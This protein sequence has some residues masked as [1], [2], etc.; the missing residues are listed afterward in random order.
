[1]AQSYYILNGVCVCVC[2]QCLQAESWSTL[3]RAP[4][5]AALS[6]KSGGSKK[7]G[8]KSSSGTFQS[9]AAAETFSPSAKLALLE[10]WCKCH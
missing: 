8:K 1:M 7:S 4:A 3:R 5:A 2:V 9:T 6:S 10:L